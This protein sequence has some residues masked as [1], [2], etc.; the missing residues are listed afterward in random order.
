MRY[1]YDMCHGYITYTDQETLFLDNHWVKRLKRIKQLGL[2]EH[3]FPSASHS[4]FEHSLG[5]SHIADKYVDVLLKNSCK[6]HYYN[7][8]Y[9]FCV[10]MAALFHDLGHGPFSHVFDNVVIQDPQNSHEIRSRRI[11]EYIFQEVGTKSGFNSAYIIDYIKEMIEPVSKAYSCIPFFDIVNNSKNSI[12]VDK[13]DYLQR[14]PRHI[15]LDIKFDPARIINKSYIEDDNIVYSNSVSNNILHMFSTRYRLHKEIY[16]HKTVKLIELMLGD[17][18]LEAD[19]HFN[20]KE[21]SKGKHFEKL[22]DSIYPTIL[23]SDNKDLSTSANILKRIENR[24]L[25]KQLWMGDFEDDSHV[26]DFIDDNHSN[27]SPDNIKFIH[28]K[29]NHCNGDESPLKNVKFKASPIQTL[30]GSN[31]VSFEEKTVLIYNISNT[32]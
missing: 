32:T 3:V 1:I 22:D 29:Y 4:R 25:Y 14:D 10:K 9:K 12:D 18:L 30:G 2:L 8:D 7:P 17:S 19:S 31:T 15:G 5:V 24:D 28:M 6:L 27:V 20:F 23:N 11:V 13:F 16:N 26:R 21:I